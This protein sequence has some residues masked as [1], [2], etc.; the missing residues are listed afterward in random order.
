MEL[1]RV[2]Y[3]VSLSLQVFSKIRNE[4]FSSVFGFLSEKAR[5]LQTQYDVSGV[6]WQLGGVQC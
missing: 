1:A 2:W 6:G 4:H 3:R 5:N